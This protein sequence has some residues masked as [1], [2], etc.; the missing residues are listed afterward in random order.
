MSDSRKSRDK[1][2]L[3]INS[4]RKSEVNIMQNI[5]KKQIIQ[6][7]ILFRILIVAIIRLNIRQMLLVKKAGLQLI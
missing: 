6:L 3:L 1:I 7:Q 4:G 2:Q 5:R